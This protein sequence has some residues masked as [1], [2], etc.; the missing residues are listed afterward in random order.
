MTAN[1]HKLIRKKIKYFIK[2]ITKS[3]HMPTVYK[4]FRNSLN[5]TIKIAK[6]SYEE[7]INLNKNN[8]KKLWQTLG[9]VVNFKSKTKF[10][11]V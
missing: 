5:R 3:K 9:H 10:H 8:L 7:L 4:Q 1:I 2:F 11:K 6:H